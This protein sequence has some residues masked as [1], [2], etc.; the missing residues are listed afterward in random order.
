MTKFEYLWV[1]THINFAYFFM[2]TY[3]VRTKKKQ[4]EKEIQ[5]II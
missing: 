3:G 1:N 4:A 2:Y 5:T